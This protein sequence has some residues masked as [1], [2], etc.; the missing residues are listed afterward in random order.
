MEI[1]FATK[2]T[3]NIQLCGRRYSTKKNQ[4]VSCMKSS[5]TIKICSFIDVL[6]NNFALLFT[7]LPVFS[8][9]KSSFALSLS[10]LLSHLVCA[11]N[12]NT[13]AT[14]FAGP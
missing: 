1:A 3:I 5:R 4:T 13:I 7:L 2:I 9:T 14:A 6:W 12:M 11:V 10:L 8:S